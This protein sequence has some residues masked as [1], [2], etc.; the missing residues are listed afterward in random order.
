[1]FGREQLVASS[2]GVKLVSYP[3]GVP[4]INAVHKAQR[5]IGEI[6]RNI[7]LLKRQLLTSRI[8]RDEFGQKSLIERAKQ[9]KI[10]DSLND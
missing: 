4:G 10:M 6:D 8:D 7:S 3:E 1:M 9:A 5:Q 2:F